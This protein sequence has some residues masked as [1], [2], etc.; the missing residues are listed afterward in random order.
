MNDFLH[1][2]VEKYN[3]QFIR[4]RLI[5]KENGFPN[6]DFQIEGRKMKIHDNFNRKKVIKLKRYVTILSVQKITVK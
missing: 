6:I 4:W 2:F 5:E 1:I 3:F